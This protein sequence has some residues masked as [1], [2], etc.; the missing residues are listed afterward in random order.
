MCIYMYISSMYVHKGKA[1]CESEL[2]AC[3]Q[4]DRATRVTLKA[5]KLKKRD[6]IANV[7]DK[8]SK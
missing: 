8:K 7:K 1:K 4:A 5:N 6:E 3:S 2:H